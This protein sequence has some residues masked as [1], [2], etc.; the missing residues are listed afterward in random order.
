[1][2]SNAALSF[3]GLARPGGRAP[4]PLLLGPLALIGLGL[5]LSRPEWRQRPLLWVL[6]AGW[7]GAIL[8][9]GLLLV[10]NQGVRWALFLTPLLCASAGLSLAAYWRRG[11][12][13]SPMRKYTGMSMASK[14]T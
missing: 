10:A 4:L 8:S 1:M 3:V 14:K 7:L 9:Q 13:K 12:P 11:P 6:G 2:I 5:G